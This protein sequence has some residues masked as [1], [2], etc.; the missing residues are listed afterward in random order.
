LSKQEIAGIQI[1]RKGMFVW[2]GLILFIAGWMFVLGILVGRGAAPVKLEVGKL[3]KELA[4]LKAKM[5]KQEQAKVDAQAS[6]KD[7]EKPSL[8]FYEALKSPQKEA[9]PF[10]ALPQTSP[11][12]RPVPEPKKPENKP[13]PVPKPQ[14][15]PPAVPSPEP[16]TKR[17]PPPKPATSPAVQ[18]GRFAVQVAAVQA[19]QNAEKLVARLKAKGYRAYHVRSE[20]A[21]RGVWH[22]VRVGAFED[23][24]AADKMLARLKSDHF[25]GMVVSTK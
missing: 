2:I 6:G 14:P 1:S 15:V 19:V 9:P 18:K 4:E 20:I 11:K 22:R 3:E 17:V 10:K 7:G 16:R 5:L 12:P 13:A 21:G 24:Q 23:R 8:G 25:S